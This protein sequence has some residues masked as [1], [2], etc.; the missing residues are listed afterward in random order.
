MN[1]KLGFLGV[2]FF[3]EGECGLGRAMSVFQIF[4]HTSNFIEA[5][6]GVEPHSLSADG[7]ARR[8]RFSIFFN[9]KQ[10]CPLK[11]PIYG[12]IC[13]RIMRLFTDICRAIYMTS[14]KRG[15]VPARP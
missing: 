5:R 4:A 3:D 9:S 12:Y 15:G 13:G 11:T 7:V 1:L 10:Y 6:L 14:A 2:L 8:P